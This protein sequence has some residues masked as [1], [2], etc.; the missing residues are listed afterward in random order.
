MSGGPER[1]AKRSPGWWGRLRE[2]ANE[3]ATTAFLSVLLLLSVLLVSSLLWVMFG[4]TIGCHAG[5]L[6][7]RLGVTEKAAA[8]KMLGFTIAGIL[9][10]WGAMAANRRANAMT[11][12]A[13]VADDTV[14]ATEIGNRQ[15]AFNDGVEQ[16]G[17]EK[18]SV[19]QGG[20]HALVYLA[21]EDEG[22]RAPIAGVLCAHIQE[23]TG[24]KDYQK[25]YGNKPSTEM[26]SLLRLLFTTKTVDE[27]RLERFWEGITPDLEGGYFCGAALENAWFR[28]AKLNS[29]QFREAKLEKAQFQG[30]DLSR[31]QF[32]AASLWNAQFQGAR[33]WG[34]QFQAANLLRAQLQGAD[35]EM[36]QFH[37]ADLCL[38]QFQ[39]ADLKR[40]QFQ[41]AQLSGSQF[42]GASLYMAGFQQTRLGQERGDT[43][44]SGYSYRHGTL[45]E[46]ARALETS[47]FHG[48][49]STFP[50]IQ[51]SFDKRIKAR[52][53]KQSDFSGV[54]FS[55]GVMAKLLADVK[56]ALKRAS[57]FDH[58]SDFEEKLIRDL[59]SEKG[60]PE[61]HTSPKEAMAGSYGEEDAER[62]IREYRESGNNPGSQPSRIVRAVAA[63]TVG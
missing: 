1:M 46:V 20:A 35:L 16:L 4:D 2:W 14:K 22:L 47:A 10:F 53:N 57:W 61:S 55:G 8:L 60:Q 7:E 11:K 39:G 52:I 44:G 25:E 29:A 30:A 51:E 34:T 58:C 24:K 12:T 48:V 42:Q 54:L 50:D 59:E 9:A 17:S 21:R 49:S 45:N 37:G 19:R 38:A 36:A 5:W 27:G 43:P 28:G 18:A 15:R 41:G 62:W 26:Q 6:Y 63:V 32:E 3:K 33:M 23:T 40:V 31:A 13:E 56:K